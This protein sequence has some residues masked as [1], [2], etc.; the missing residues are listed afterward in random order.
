MSDLGQDSP[1]VGDSLRSGLD[2]ARYQMTSTPQRKYVV[3]KENTDEFVILESVQRVIDSLRFV[4]ILFREFVNL[5]RDL[6]AFFLAVDLT[7]PG[8][9]CTETRVC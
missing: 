2:K 1:A 6:K 9:Q 5:L 4:K 7:I 3:C 8:N